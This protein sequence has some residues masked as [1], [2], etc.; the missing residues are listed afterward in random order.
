MLHTSFRLKFESGSPKIH[1]IQLAANKI[2]NGAKTTRFQVLHS[3]KKPSFI[4]WLDETAKTA[5]PLCAGSIPARASNLFDNFQANSSKTVCATAGMFA[6][7]TCILPPCFAF[8]GSWLVAVSQ[9]RRSA[10]AS[11]MDCQKRQNSK[12]TMIESRSR[13]VR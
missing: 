10:R 8:I 9:R 5:K 2:Q 7:S 11:G 4:N 1:G 12:I 3:T 13:P 6:G